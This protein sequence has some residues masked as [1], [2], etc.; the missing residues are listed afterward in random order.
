MGT[1]PGAALHI[2]NVGHAVVAGVAG[3]AGSSDKCSKGWGM[4]VNS[5]LPVK[6]CTRTF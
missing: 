4:G 6:N 5:Q 1:V 2:A 3:V